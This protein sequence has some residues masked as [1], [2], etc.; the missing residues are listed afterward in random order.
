MEEIE[1]GKQIR[2]RISFF[3]LQLKLVM[4]YSL[5][6]TVFV[7]IAYSWFY[8]NAIE[9][10]K[11]GLAEDLRFML[12]GTARKIDGDEFEALV[13]EGKPRTDGYTDDPRFWRHVKW[14]AT[15]YDIDSRTGLFTYIR[16]K[17]PNE[18]IFVGSNAAL[19]Y[20][21]YGAKF[22]EPFTP[23][24]RPDAILKGLEETT[25]LMDIYTDPWGSWIT[26]YTPIRNS[27]GMVV[28]GL[29]I[30]F[31]ADYILAVQRETFVKLFFSFILIYLIL[32]GLII[33]LSQMLTK[34][35]IQL[36]RLAKQF[37]DGDYGGVE[38]ASILKGRM[39]DEIS[40]LSESLS[41]MAAR[42]R[43]RELSLRHQVE[44]LKLAID[45]RLQ[46]R[47]DKEDL[48][49]ILTGQV[50]PVLEVHKSA[51]LVITPEQ[52]Y[53]VLYL[54]GVEVEKL[55][56]IAHLIELVS[57][58]GVYQF[59]SQAN[60]DLLWFNLA[61]ALKVSGDL[62]GIWLLGFHSPA[63]YFS[64]D[65]ISIL[66]SL[67]TQLAV[68]LYHIQ[69]AELMRAL[70]T[71]NIKNQE[72]DRNRLARD[73]H[74][75]VLSKMAML[76]F[77]L[78][79]KETPQLVELYGE[80]TTSL[81]QAI[82]DLRPPLLIYGLKAAL[83]DMVDEVAIRIGEKTEITIEIVEE[84]RIHYPE[85][86]EEQIFRIIQQ[87]VDNAVRHARAQNVWVS[88]KLLAS[89]LCLNVEDD[90]IGFET[91]GRQDLTDLLNRRHFGLVGM[92]ERA[93]AI[94]AVLEIHSRQG[95]GTRIKVEW[96]GSI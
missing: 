78:D 23:D 18:V 29:G 87:A 46:T 52:D 59:S 77:Y 44:E 15:A 65:E 33:A 37:G 58:R 30:D 22:L 5:L 57:E 35:I 31:S 83:T 62:T 39:Y 51:L 54:Q 36:T 8:Y 9:I 16:G 27:R 42:V 20:P 75:N 71:A 3:S 95:Y 81:R 84:E 13:A 66:K 74:D 64:R 61:L 48:V 6:F 10:V 90:G 53:Q 72:N 12:E 79:E 11:T 17:K 25:I 28:G 14:L 19:L 88:G 50:L 63:Q 40:Q 69:Q 26:G 86:V 94:N 4:A 93:S 56:D 24:Y 70:Y 32:L 43:Q 60:N 1:T 34:P 7:G 82:Y 68:A 49:A 21:P 76:S 80:L 91:L 73:I 2:R 89:G 45:D 47:L 96:S 41:V 85:G 67:S 38:L 55:P 92:H